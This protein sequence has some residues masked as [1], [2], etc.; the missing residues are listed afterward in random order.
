MRL[1]WMKSL[2]TIALLSVGTAGPS[3]GAPA[4]ASAAAALP[5]GFTELQP[6]RLAVRCDQELERRRARMA[7]M[8]RPRHPGRI[9]EEFNALSLL[10][11]NFDDPLGVLQN[12]APDKDLRA[13]AQACLE[14][15]VPF[16]T[17]LFQSTA[18]YARVAALKTADPQEQS[19]RQWLIEQF[20]DAG[21]TLPEA[22]RAQAKAIQDELATLSLRF[23][24]NV[25]DVSTTVAVTPAETEGLSEDWRAARARDEQGN[26]LVGM[27]YPSFGP[28]MES[29]A[30]ARAR[31]RVW[32][33]FQNRAAPENLALMDRALALRSQLAQVYGYPDY[34]T[35]ALRRKMAGTPQAV[36]GFLASVKAAVDAVE[37]RELEE[38]RREKVALADVGDDEAAAADI[39]VER[40]DVGYLQQRIK[41][42]R[43][44]VDQEALRAY[45]P[46]EAAV[47]F[48]LHVA[49]QLYGIRFEARAV[50]AWHEQV[51]YLEVVDEAA[52]A[53][54]P[55]LGA[56]YLD[57]YPR[58]G[59]FSHAAVFGVRRGSALA[60]Q[61][62]IKALICNL[63]DKGLTPSELE[64][65]FHEFGHAL[66]GVLS[67]ARYADQSGTAV[68]QDFVE[69]PSM[70]FEEWARREVSLRGFAAV[71]PQC[72]VLSHE[73]ITQ[74]AAA[75]NF[76]AGM[77][78]ARQWLFASFDLAL[79]TGA[80]GSAL[81]TWE[82]MEGDSRLGHVA[83]TMMPA[84]FSHL[85]GGYE[86]GYYS[87]M[88][89]EVL[90]LDML[91]AYQG[92]LLDAA[93]GRRYRH[94]ILEPGGSRPPQELVEEFLGR[95]PSPDAFYA[96]ITG[97]R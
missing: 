1:R 97:Q 69:A 76:G 41:R 49:E 90:A 82:R 60:G 48:V 34:A 59:K 35:F 39:R 85:M 74:M 58:P 24:R 84:S 92:N 37:S 73:Q 45:F 62:P 13:A 15:L 10:T 40:W 64:T 88:W 91:S 20:E 38:L 89:S 9:L 33:A 29:A 22:Q 36:A 68:R 96:E 54:A 78:Y 2:S 28:F 46:T 14:K 57:L 81:A 23:Q 87:Y 3:A 61:H 50:P 47:R 43:Y 67:K 75:R 17:E 8:E 93:V 72:P 71:C 25:N 11:G 53:R 63:N 77:R 55:A 65:L 26:F 32:T 31:R 56:I 94:S 18:L 19:Y 30:D 83:G 6:H 66:H 4:P 7:Q 42:A 27:D 16:G 86:A 95:K 44:N 5:P 79:H 80:P 52:P 21:A 12:A 51:R 70:M